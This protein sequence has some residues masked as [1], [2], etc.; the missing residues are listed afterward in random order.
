MYVCIGLHD[1]VACASDN[2]LSEEIALVDN[3]E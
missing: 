2:N 3:F 1:G